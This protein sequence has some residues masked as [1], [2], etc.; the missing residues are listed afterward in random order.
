MTDTLAG[1]FFVLYLFANVRIC[2]CVWLSR[3]CRF[4]LKLL[5]NRYDD[6]SLGSFLT[7][8]PIK[9]GSN[10]YSYCGGNPVSRVDPSG[11][12]D[13]DWNQYFDDVV[14][15]L[16]GYYDSGNPASW[17]DGI[18]GLLNEATTDPI[19]AYIDLQLG[20][21][22]PLCMAFVDNDP[23][24][25]GV[26]MGGTLQIALA[27]AA[28]LA[29]GGE[30]K[31]TGPRKMQRVKGYSLLRVD[32]LVEEGGLLKWK[33]KF[34]IDWHELRDVDGWANGKNLPHYHSRGPGGIGRHRPWE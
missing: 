7:R 4:G 29:K 31:L 18:I 33:Q 5:G 3:G 13:W 2:R 19:G 26:G 17:V 22:K 20:P 6:A 1:H 25:F 28:P 10:W 23:Y 11:L 32:S 27:K 15:V 16:H 30:F 8:D 14:Q 21:L 24:E 9:D 34:R 12:I